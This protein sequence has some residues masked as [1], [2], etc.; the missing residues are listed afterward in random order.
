MK[1]LISYLLLSIIIFTSCDNEVKTPK[2]RAYF[3]ID[4]PDYEYIKLKEDLPYKFDYPEFVKIE[5]PKAEYPNWINLVYKNHKAKIYITYYQVEDNLNAL[6]GDAHEFA[7]KH[8]SKANDIQ[9]LIV[10]NDSAKTYGMIFRIEGSETA[11]PINFFLTD[12]V[13]NYLRGALY[14]EFKPNNDSLQPVIES[15]EKD[16]SRMIRTFEWKN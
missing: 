15:I 4:I 14:F 7:Y 1:Y 11:T 6:L 12:S 13:N 16:I 5:Y 10:E 8:I 9:T 2:P 3:R